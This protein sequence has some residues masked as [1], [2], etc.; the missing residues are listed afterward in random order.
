[1]AKIC[2]DTAYHQNKRDYEVC[3]FLGRTCANSYYK[4]LA[5]GYLNEAFSLLMPD[6]IMLGNLLHELSVANMSLMRYEEGFDLLQKAYAF[7]PK[8]KVVIYNL[9]LYYD[10]QRKDPRK[11]LPYYQDY[12]QHLAVDSTSAIEGSRNYSIKAYIESRIREIEE[13]KFWKGEGR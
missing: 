10:N 8:D 11:A 9:A 3:L 2:L 12:F 5:I 6:S 13:E 7:N 1:M 4:E